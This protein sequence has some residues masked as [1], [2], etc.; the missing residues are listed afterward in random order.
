MKTRLLRNQ[1]HTSQSKTLIS[2][3]LH[4]P[5]NRSND[6]Q[7]RKNNSAQEKQEFS[8]QKMFF[9]DLARGA[10]LPMNCPVC[11]RET[12]L[13]GADYCLAH[14]RALENLR[15]AF[16]KW[17][18]AYEGLTLPDFLQRVQKSPGMGPKAKE[19]AR[20]LSENSSRWK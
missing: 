8:F 14:N 20:F 1:I 13:V 9:H 5:K 16:E 12:E 17:T 6:F 18:A 11:S 2:Y 3:A 19:I 7:N 4:H 10:I 15:R